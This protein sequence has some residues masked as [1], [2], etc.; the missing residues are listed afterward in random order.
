M[1]FC[2]HL[3]SGSC[4]L[5]VWDADSLLQLGLA[6]L[7][8]R[9]LLRQGRDCAESL[10]EAR[11]GPCEPPPAHSPSTRLK[12]RAER[13]QPAFGSGGGPTHLWR[14]NLAQT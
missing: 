12:P 1:A 8:L 9:Q 4:A 3:A 13:L 10:Q 7:D 14:S 11:P 2:R 6:H 5:E